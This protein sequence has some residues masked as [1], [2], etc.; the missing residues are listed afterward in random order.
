MSTYIP[1][2]STELQEMLN[3]IGV[4]TIDELFAEIPNNLRLNK[5]LDIPCGMS[6]LEMTRELTSLSE[7]NKT[8]DKNV[9]FLG[10][11]AYDHIIPAAIDH[12]LYEA[13][14][15]LHTLLTNLKFH[16]V[17]FSVSMNIKA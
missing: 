3:V 5:D 6:E 12:L 7:M 2:T 16:K 8:V 15:S 1:H 17:L 13:I 11:G 14:F 4:K 9:C 10:G